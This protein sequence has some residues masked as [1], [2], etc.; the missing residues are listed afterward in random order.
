MSY[1]IK[2][3]QDVTDVAP[4]FGFDAIQEARFPW[5]ELGCEDTGFAYHRIKPGQRG[6]AHRHH[7][8]EEIYVVMGG[9]GQVKLDDEVIELRPLDAVRIAPP[10]VRAFAAGPDGLDLLVF[11]PHRERD[12]EVLSDHDPW[13][14]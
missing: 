14:R 11:G 7:E 5:R 6:G 1:A 2:N 13:Q 3:L 9:S 8:A 10:V 4:R 12:G